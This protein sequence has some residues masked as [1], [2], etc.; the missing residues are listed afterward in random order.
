MSDIQQKHNTLELALYPG[1][2]GACVWGKVR[3]LK[4]HWQDISP[5]YIP[6]DGTINIWDND[7]VWVVP[8][9][10]CAL[11]F[12]STLWTG[13]WGKKVDVNSKPFQPKA[14]L[15]RDEGKEKQFTCKATGGIQTWK[16][17]SNAYKLFGHKSCTVLTLTRSKQ[18]IN[19]HAW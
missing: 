10:Q 11:G 5:K 2:Y 17:W 7:L 19:Y 15:P 1:L 3:T 4:W 9:V 14:G 18:I 16:L 12:S 6:R 13:W 8:E